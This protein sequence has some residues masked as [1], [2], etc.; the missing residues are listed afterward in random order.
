[1]PRRHSM[2]EKREVLRRMRL[3]H[4]IR[5][6]NK[7]TGMHR[8]IIRDLK[9][10]AENHGWFNQEEI[11]PTEETLQKLLLER[12]RNPAR[13]PHL[14][15]PYQEQLRKWI[16]D[17]YSY[18]VIHKLISPEVMVSEATVRRY[19]QSHFPKAPK[20]TFILDLQVR[21]KLGK[22]I[23]DILGLFTTPRRS[24]TG[25]PGYSPVV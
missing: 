19:C 25:K 18:I 1:M 23:L 24:G 21:E 20:P 2:T 4:S 17:E 22:W 13:V 10:L 7:E 5:Q 14:L 11:L 3:G 8:T 9:R 16:E 12:K 6:I 15:D